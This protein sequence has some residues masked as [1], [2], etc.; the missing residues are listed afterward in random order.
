M[1]IDTKRV[2]DF[3]LEKLRTGDRAEFARMVEAYSGVIYRLAL[4]MLENSQDAED[5][6]QETFIKA[7][8]AI[9]NFDGRS[10]LATWLYRI[11]TNEAL[12][13]LRKHKRI[14]ISLDEPADTEEQEAEPL[15]IVDWCCMPED[16][17]MSTEARAHLDQAIEKLP[18]SLRV[19]F[20]LR[21][22]EGLST[23]ETG[24]VLNLSETAVK[25]RLSRARL[26]L[27]ELLTGYY[28]ERMNRLPGQNSSTGVDA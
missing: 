26:R 16:E 4:K 2:D 5:V 20:L 23:L 24:E 9:K 11:A 21:D 7:L 10:N 8:R 17:L 1:N 13:L 25:T 18:H 15:Q 27:R 19:V 28:G 14:T 6:L 12:M 22:I 3:S